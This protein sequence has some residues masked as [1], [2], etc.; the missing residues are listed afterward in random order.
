MTEGRQGDEGLTD[1][2]E[3]CLLNIFLTEICMVGLH[4]R[5]SERKEIGGRTST[6]LNNLVQTV[7]TPLK[8]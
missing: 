5:P 2:K 8:N 6:A 4:V 1:S 3:E 7:A